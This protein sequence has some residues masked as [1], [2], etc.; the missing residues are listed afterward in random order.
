MP[1]S[2]SQSAGVSRVAIFGRVWEG[3]KGMSPALAREVVKLKFSDQDVARMHEL[4]A[5][6]SAGTISTEEFAELGYYVDVTNLLTSL[7]SRARMALKAKQRT[8]V[9]G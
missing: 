1:R 2:L 3:E 9:R 4:A 8:A 6:N 7:Q 5:K